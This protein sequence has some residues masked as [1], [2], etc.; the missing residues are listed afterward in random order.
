MHFEHF[1][2]ISLVYK[3]IHNWKI[4]VTTACFC[5]KKKLFLGFGTKARADK[6]DLTT[7]IKNVIKDDVINFQS[8]VL[9]SDLIKPKS[10]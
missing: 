7:S 6:R 2:V 8:R 5:K 9:P 3:S 1:D 4:A 10:N